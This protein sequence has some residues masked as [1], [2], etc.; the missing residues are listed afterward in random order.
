MREFRVWMVRAGQG[1]YLIDNFLDEKIIAIGWNELGEINNDITYSELKHLYRLGY[2]DDS[3]GRVNQC[4]GQIWRFLTEFAVGDKV[5]TY[6]P[7]SRVYFLGEIKSNY[8]YNIDLEYFHTRKVSW[9]D[10]GVD[11]DL[12]S[13]NTK[14]TLGSIST[15]F[16]LTEGVWEELLENHPGY[17]SEVSL[18]EIEEFQKLAEE[19][20]LR[21]LKDD[22]IFRSKE[23]IKDILS[24]ISWQDTEVLAAGLLRSLGYKT[25]FTSRGSDLGSDIIASPDDL[26][27][28]EPLIKVE[29]KKHK[30]KISAPDIRNFIGGMR[31]HH[32]G[33]YISISGFSKEARY[34]AERA[35][36]AITL[37][38]SDW[39]VDLLIS[40]YETLDPEIKAIVPLRKIYWPV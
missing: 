21:R 4:V 17:I 40:N 30:D 13:T 24:N 23:F 37:I 7:S 1:G 6:D 25:K 38:D 27:L 11:R 34:E 29:V 19:E 8:L 32:K 31:R 39:L 33:I 3:D 5:V 26:F 28:E 22:V 9:I 16:E 2:P 36:F 10:N 12:L 18:Q 14:N 20:E 35:N 15:I